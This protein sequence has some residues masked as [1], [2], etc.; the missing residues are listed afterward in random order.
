MMN[1]L[2]NLLKTIEIYFLSIFE[3]KIHTK[4]MISGKLINM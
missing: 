3:M 4:G 2:L 1:E